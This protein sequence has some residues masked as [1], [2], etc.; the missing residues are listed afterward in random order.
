MSKG[1]EGVAKD[2]II[3]FEIKGKK[4]KKEYIGI[5]S[6][7]YGY[8]LAKPNL[9]ANGEISWVPYCWPRSLAGCIHEIFQSKVIMEP[10]STLEDILQ[11]QKDIWAQ[12]SNQ[13][14]EPAPNEK[15]LKELS[16]FL[17]GENSSSEDDSDE[18]E[19]ED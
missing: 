1:R 2:R 5:S 13:L 3:I 17:S 16:E 14:K 18:I 19:D 9:K 12:I 10:Y 7:K 11:N 15:V 6:N 8:F 4:K